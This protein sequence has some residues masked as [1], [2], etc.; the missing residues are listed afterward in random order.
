MKKIPSGVRSE[1]YN[2]I[3][4][5]LWEA[6]LLRSRINLNYILTAYVL[7]P[8]ATQEP[9]RDRKISFHFMIYD[10]EKTIR[11]LLEANSIP[12]EIIRCYRTDQF[13]PAE[14]KKVY[15]AEDDLEILFALNTL[16]ENAGYDVVISHCGAPMLK[17][18][19]PST[20]V[21]ILDNKMPDVDGVDVCRHLKAQAATRDIPVIM[22]SALRGSMSKARAAGADD[23]LEKPFQMNELLRLVA[24]HVDK[25]HRIQNSA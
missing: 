1:L 7:R 13:L 20:D 21:F 15:L 24:K 25:G 5:R 3:E 17:S 12:F 6:Y 2:A 10:W 14:K 9:L 16:L 8:A 23:F 11:P 22:I 19:L 4:I 18:D